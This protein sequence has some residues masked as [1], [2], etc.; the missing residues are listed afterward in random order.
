VTSC[1][2]ARPPAIARELDDA[3]RYRT[4]I[5]QLPLVV[6]VDALDAESSN[7][8]TSKQ[9]EPLLGFT[10]E[11][12]ASETGLFVRALHPDDRD[13][14]LAAHARTHETHQPLSIEYRLIAKDGHVVWVRDEGVVVVDDAGAPL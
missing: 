12:W 11:E 4:L 7:I 10:I 9:V 13:R 8:F 6:Y 5:E 3:R 1:G 14:V 2:E